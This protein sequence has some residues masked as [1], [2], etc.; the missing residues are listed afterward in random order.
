MVVSISRKNYDKIVDHARREFPL[1]CCGLVG[2]TI[3][4]DKYL[5]EGLYELYNLDQSSEHFSMDPKEQLSTVREMRKKGYTLL[6]NYHSHPYTPS[7]P[8][9]ED[10][11]LAYDEKMIYGI[12]SLEKQEP[13]LNF[14]KINPSKSIEK[15]RINIIE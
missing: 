3:C 9:E 6:G 5:I 11:R 4:D 15:L 10:I 12:I 8:S 7:R 13:I 14:F 2:G 1:E